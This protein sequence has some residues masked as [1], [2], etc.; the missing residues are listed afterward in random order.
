MEL[1]SNNS[2]KR[3]QIVQCIVPNLA[4]GEYTVDAIQKLAAKNT[5]KT[6]EKSLTFGVD[7]ARFRLSSTDIYSVYPPANTTGDYT[8]HLPHVVFNRKTLP[9]E[10][11]I[12]GK[13]PAFLKSN[14]AI[15]KANVRFA[16][17]P[18]FAVLG[19]RIKNIS[20]GSNVNSAIDRESQLQGYFASFAQ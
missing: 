11:T 6:I 8:H 10:R 7:A 9:W 5:I 4:A 19:N 15:N 3:T 17:D 20:V 18:E 1:E 2:I 12:D 13:S 16:S 14:D